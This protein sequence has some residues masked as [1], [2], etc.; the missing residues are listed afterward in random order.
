LDFCD[1]EAA[2]EAF[3]KGLSIYAEF[4]HGSHP[5]VKRLEKNKF[6]IKNLSM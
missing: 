1:Y 4:F 3:N 2:E 5:L 6:Q